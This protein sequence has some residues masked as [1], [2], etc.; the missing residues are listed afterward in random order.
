MELKLKT[1]V[2]YVYRKKGVVIQNIIPPRNQH[3]TMLMNTMYNFILQNR[4]K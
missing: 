2:E 3:E 1:I 4:N